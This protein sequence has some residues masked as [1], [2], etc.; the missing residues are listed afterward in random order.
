MIGG[1]QTLVGQDALFCFG[2]P[3][4]LFTQ[5]K[6]QE[7]DSKIMGVEKPR[8]VSSYSRQKTRARIRAHSAG[9]RKVVIYSKRRKASKS[10]KKQELDQQ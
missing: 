3:L 10:F 4:F 7:S 6:I 2:D 1:G 9:Q 8:D 5:Y